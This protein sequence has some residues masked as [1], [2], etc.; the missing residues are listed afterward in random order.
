MN[1]RIAG[2]FLAVV[3]VI[4]AASTSFAGAG[5]AYAD[6][7]CSKPLEAN[8]I[9]G[10][11]VADLRVWL[12]LQGA[13]VADLRWYISNNGSPVTN[14]EFGDRVCGIT[15]GNGSAIYDQYWTGWDPP[16]VKDTYTLTVVF[17]AGPNNGDNFGS[18]SFLLVP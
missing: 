10:S 14:G 11:S 12:K 4:A 2:L 8:K 17:D 7:D 6:I 1:P 5:A 15:T 3:L 16:T 9:D 18:D 13:A